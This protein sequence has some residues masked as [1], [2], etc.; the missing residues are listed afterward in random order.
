MKM[1]FRF[2]NFSCV[3]SRLLVCYNSGLGVRWM[4]GLGL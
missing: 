3:T 1:R 4:M 2:D